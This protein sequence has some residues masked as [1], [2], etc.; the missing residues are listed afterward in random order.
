MINQR[1]LVSGVH[2]SSL[3]F[4]V[5]SFKFCLVYLLGSA[6]LLLAQPLNSATD[7]ER[8][9][10]V[11]GR[12]LFRDRT[13]VGKI[14]FIKQG[15]RTGLIG[16]KQKLTGESLTLL[17]DVAF[18]PG[19]TVRYFGAMLELAAGEHMISSVVLDGE[20]VPRLWSSIT[21][22]LE[23]GEKIRS[24]ERTDTRM[25]FRGKSGWSLTYFQAGTAQRVEL[26]FPAKD[27]EPEE[28]RSLTRD[29]LS[30]LKDLVDLAL[31]DLKRQGA[32]LAP[33][34]EK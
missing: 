30:A 13:P 6:A 15:A 21:Y 5:S 3:K 20:E 7:Y 23:T 1:L 32:Q 12:T 34:T 19:D 24:T 33:V 28:V 31:F 11:P 9:L 26:S 4:Q 29:E 25:Q 17:T 18:I 16:K 8:E 2:L 10:Q 27:K 22:M 14:S